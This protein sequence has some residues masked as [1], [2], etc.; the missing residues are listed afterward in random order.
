MDRGR[1]LGRVIERLAEVIQLLDELV[2]QRLHLFPLQSCGVI[3]DLLTIHRD[4]LDDAV[5][6]RVKDVLQSPS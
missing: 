6:L 1:P 3:E 2:D 5:A 4:A